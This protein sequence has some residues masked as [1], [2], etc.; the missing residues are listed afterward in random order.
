[1]ATTRAKATTQATAKRKV[2][3]AC[4]TVSCRQA[5]RGSQLGVTSLLP[6]NHESPTI[7]AMAMDSFGELGVFV[8]VVDAQ[9]FTR[10]GK[11]LGLTASGVSRVIARLEERLGVRL[12][13]RSTRSLSLTDDG[14]AYYARC[15][16]ILADLADANKDLARVR[17][18]PR[19]RLRVDMPIV[20]GRYVIGPAIHELL[21]RYPELS[22]DLSVRDQ[23]ID[24]IAEGMDVVLRMAALRESDLVRKQLGS[25]RMVFV[26]APRYLARH[27]KPKTPA[28]L[29]AHQQVGFLTGGAALP[30]QLASGARL[31]FQGRLHTNSADTARASV[32][33]G[34][35]I[36][37]VF[38]FHVREELARGSLVTVLEDHE[39]PPKP[40]FALYGRDK[41]ALPRVRAFLEFAQAKID[42]A[43]RS[44]S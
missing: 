8:R 22:I 39:P 7:V 32:L 28:D 34:V 15:T 13:N 35:G 17:D 11:S 26:V 16:K 29:R 5:D 10:A 1:M 6:R 27:G 12:L 40:V 25:I 30:W 36:A 19:G 44:K 37:Q 43:P 2:D 38:E 9:N 14:A 41:L 20:L 42:G 31:A 23:L 4:E 18:E 24:P 3:S 21:R 33:A